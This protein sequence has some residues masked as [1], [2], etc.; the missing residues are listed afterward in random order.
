MRHLS[1]KSENC[2]K[3][4]P[5]PHTPAQRLEEMNARVEARAGRNLPLAIGVG[6]LLGA[7]A[8]V[9]IVY[10]QPVFTVFVSLVAAFCGA[11]ISLALRHRDVWLP[12]VGM[13]VAVGVGPL[14]GGFFGGLTGLL[15]TFGGG[16]LLLVWY[17]AEC[18]MGARPLQLPDILWGL[19]TVLYLGGCTLGAAVLDRSAGAW[20]LIGFL[21]VVIAHDIGAYAVGRTFGRHPM[22]PAIS[23]KKTWEGQAGALG[24]AVLAGAIG[25]APLWG[26]PWWAGA[27]SGLSLMF[28]AT[29][30]DLLESRVKRWIGVKDMSSWIPGHGGLLDR[31]DAILLSAP[32]ALALHLIWIAIL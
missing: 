16:V 26:I 5:E 8:W 29:F 22:A 21:I 31:L 27:I 6:L 3:S 23:P 14:A 7:I 28:S 2:L 32:M 24:A 25:L 20:A 11:E 4:D 15:S 19:L 18:R 30:G 1:A 12:R 10:S 17:A 9:C 13:A